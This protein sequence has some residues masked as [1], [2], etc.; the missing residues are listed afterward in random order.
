MAGYP[1]LRTQVK[2]GPRDI[3]QFGLKGLMR[4]QKTWEIHPVIIINNNIIIIIKSI[5]R[6]RKKQV[7]TVAK[8]KNQININAL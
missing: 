4:V 8:T 7:T 1:A 2:Y 5:F 6:W 3:P